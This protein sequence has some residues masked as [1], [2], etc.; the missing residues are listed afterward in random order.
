MENKIRP[1][2]WEEN[3]D[4]ICKKAP[5]DFKQ[6]AKLE[7]KLQVY[8]QT[9]VKVYFPNGILQSCKTPNELMAHCGMTPWV[10]PLPKN[11]RNDWSRLNNPKIRKRPVPLHYHLHNF[12]M[13][14]VPSDY[15]RLQ[16]PSLALQGD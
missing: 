8:F 9:I 3:W 7:K 2:S 11:D 15:Y 13:T 6:Q 4:Q 5:S 10:I 14:R 12:M 16:R 1:Q